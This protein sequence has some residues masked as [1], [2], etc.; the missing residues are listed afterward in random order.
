MIP[1]DYGPMEI[2]ENR[3]RVGLCGIHRPIDTR[4]HTHTCLHIHHTQI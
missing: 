2:P 4:T 1:I 3:D